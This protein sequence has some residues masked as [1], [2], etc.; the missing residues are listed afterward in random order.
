MPSFLQPT[1]HGSNC[2]PGAA[3][4]LGV[5]STLGDTSLWLYLEVRLGQRGAPPWQ[6]PT[7][8]LSCERK[9]VGT[10]A[11]DG[12]QWEVPRGPS[13]GQDTWLRSSSPRADGPSALPSHQSTNEDINSVTRVLVALEMYSCNG[14]GLMDF[15][16]PPLAQLVKMASECSW[17][18]PLVEVQT[19]TRLAHFTYVARDHEA[20]MA[21]SQKAIQIGMKHLQACSP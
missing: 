15:T 5:L 11:V 7:G 10:W 21:C 19:L 13:W 14:L 12:D 9:A 4:P 20:T 1:G 17:S 16:V 6:G 2:P 8:H 3:G 18:D